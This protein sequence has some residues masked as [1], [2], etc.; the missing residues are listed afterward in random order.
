[1]IAVSVTIETLGLTWTHWHR[2]TTAIEELGFAGIFRSDHLT[3]PMPPDTATL[4]LVVTLTDLAHRTHRVHFGS[5]VAPV[6]LRNP[7]ILAHQAA[8][9]DALSQGRLILGLGAGWNDR[10]HDMFGFTLGD[11]P[12]RMARFE[13]ALEIITQLFRAQEPVTYTGRFYR[14]QDAQLLTPAYHP[15]GPSILIGGS[16]PRRTLPLVARYATIWNGQGL[17]P[18][19]FIERSA[20]LDDLLKAAGRHPSAVKRTV[21]LLAVCGRDAADFEQ[22][23]GWLR[24]YFPAHTPLDELLTFLRTQLQAFIGTPDELVAYI[25]AYRAAGADE[26]VLQWFGVDDI[27]GLQLIAQDVLPH[28]TQ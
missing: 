4:D 8:A 1:M 14:L 2:L 16:G 10:E 12:T 26:V 21:L 20:L 28:V 9:L 13:E 3:G 22:R 24:R 19:M 7:V 18:E 15:Q 27:A 25:R 17:T 5:L 23:V 11:I 6:S